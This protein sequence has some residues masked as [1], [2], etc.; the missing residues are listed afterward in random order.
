[1][2]YKVFR[3]FVRQGLRWFIA[4]LDC[5]KLHGHALAGPSIILSNHPN[6][7][8]DALVLAA[9]SPGEIRYLVRGDIF[10]NPVVNVVLRSLYMLP[11]YK[12]REDPEFAVKNDFTFDACLSHLK[13]GKH[14]LIFPEGRSDNLWKL[15][16]FMNGG[17]TAIME[18]AYRADIPLQIQAYALSYSSFR[19]V[20]KAMQIKALA[21]LD[22]TDFIVDSQVETV[23]VIKLLRAN[24]LTNM[25]EE[26][27]VPPVVERKGKEWMRVPAKIGY[28]SHYWFYKLWRDYVRKKTEGTIFYDSILFV[29]LLVSYPLVVF[30]LSALIGL[31]LG[32]WVGVVVFV[33]LPGLSYCMVQYQPV[34]VEQDVGQPKANTF[35]K[36]AL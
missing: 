5:S 22:T 21:P 31:F 34:R 25:N 12:P 8:F 28:F 1:M 4:D 19:F 3:Y 14:I 11:I 26:P 24:L 33:L 16:P 13:E 32:F 17:I 10:Q 18:R 20:P 23:A 30:C 36:T 15:R 2:F 9:Y 6:S 7:L 27:Y 29:A 35:G